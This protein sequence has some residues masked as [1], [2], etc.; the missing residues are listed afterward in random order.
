MIAPGVHGIAAPNFGAVTT[1]CTGLAPPNF[2]AAGSVAWPF[3]RLT[4][5][6]VSSSIL[7]DVPSLL[8]TAVKPRL[9]SGPSENGAVTGAF[10][11]NTGAP[12]VKVIGPEKPRLG[13]DPTSLATWR[14]GPATLTEPWNCRPAGIGSAGRVRSTRVA[15][16]RTASL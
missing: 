15:P 12:E 4:T 14:K 13:T 5:T 8:R 9:L 2:S 16:S 11:T 10:S 6:V 7:P 3:A 1:R